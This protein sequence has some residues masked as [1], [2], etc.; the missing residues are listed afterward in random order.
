MEALETVGR[1][2]TSPKGLVSARIRRSERRTAS[3]RQRSSTEP[4]PNGQARQLRAPPTTRLVADAV[5]M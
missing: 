1:I 3:E 5:Q 4:E 2:E